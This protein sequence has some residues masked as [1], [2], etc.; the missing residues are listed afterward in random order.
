MSIINRTQKKKLIIIAALC[1]F[2]SGL[3]F[4]AYS[5]KEHLNNPNQKRI[6][7]INHEYSHQ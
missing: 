7:R 3:S 1:G 5:I 6:N 2:M 4:F